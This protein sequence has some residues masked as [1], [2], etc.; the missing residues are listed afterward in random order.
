MVAGGRWTRKDNSEWGFGTGSWLLKLEQ[1]ISLTTEDLKSDD[2]LILLDKP[3]VSL[4]PLVVAMAR[5]WSNVTHD[6]DLMIKC[7]QSS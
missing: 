1:S 3:V 4:S 2:V 7:P 5:A 6:P